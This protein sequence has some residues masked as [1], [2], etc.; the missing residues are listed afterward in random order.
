VE[1]LRWKQTVLRQ[2]DAAER[3]PPIA[4]PDNPP[5]F[6]KVVVAGRF[7]PELSA[8]Y[9]AEVRETANGPQ[10]GARLIVPLEREGAATILV[11]RGWVPLKRSAPFDQPTAPVSVQ[12][13]LHPPDTASW[14]SAADDPPARLFYTLDPAKI[15]STLGI[16]NVAPFVLV[17]MGPVDASRWP[18]PAQVLPR[19]PNNH[20]VYAIT[21]Y[22]LAIALLAVFIIWVRKELTVS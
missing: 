17:S 12:G 11:D 21:W 8:L 18:Q 20:L 4:L 10:M 1:C 9:G 13:Y 2:I 22:G 19:P 15:G 7:H 14:F 3:N 6:A 16:A 5:A